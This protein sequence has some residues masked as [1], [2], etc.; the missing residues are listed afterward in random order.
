MTGGINDRSSISYLMKNCY[1]RYERHF[2]ECNG[3][4]ESINVR[5]I[6]EISYVIHG[7]LNSLSLAIQVGASSKYMQVPL[8]ISD[9]IFYHSGV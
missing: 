9:T 1:F 6:I 8:Y 4:N 3:L 7:M 2:S 5:E